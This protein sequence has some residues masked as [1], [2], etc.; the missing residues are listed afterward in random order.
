MWLY[1]SGTI[2]QNQ[3]NQSVISVILTVRGAQITL[4]TAVRCALMGI[5]W[6]EVLARNV[7]LAVLPAMM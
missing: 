1:N 4:R 7:M 2:G 6:M 3:M 5:T